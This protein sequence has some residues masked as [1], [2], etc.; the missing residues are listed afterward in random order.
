MTEE[1]EMYLESLKTALDIEVD[2]HGSRTRMAH[3]L[4]VSIIRTEKEIHGLKTGL[5]K[6]CGEEMWREGT[7]GDSIALCHSCYSNENLSKHYP[8]GVTKVTKN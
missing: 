1:L 6:E 2:L 7:I 3:D 5:C 4:R 8:N